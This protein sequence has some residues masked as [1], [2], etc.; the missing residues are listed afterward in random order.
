MFIYMGRVPAKQD[1][2]L[3]GLLPWLTSASTPS[4][5]P[6]PASNI[7]SEAETGRATIESKTQTLKCKFNPLELTT[8][9]EIQI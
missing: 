3:Q 9:D 1:E 2:T 8:E 4:F 7:S 5:E 6:S